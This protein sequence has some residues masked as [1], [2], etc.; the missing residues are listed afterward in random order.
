[1]YASGFAT[2]QAAYD[3]AQSRLWAG[4]SAVEDRLASSRFLH[5]DCVTLSDVF[6]FPTVVR[7]EA[8]CA[9]P[10]RG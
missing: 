5:G 10:G 8:A 2:T 4:L 3:R 7:M 6:L 1:M 9:P